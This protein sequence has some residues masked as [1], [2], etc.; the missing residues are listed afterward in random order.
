MRSILGLSFLLMS[1][2]PAVLKASAVDQSQLDTLGQSLQVKYALL[3]N[4]DDTQ[5]RT[6]IPT[7]DCFSA[8]I[9]LS[10]SSITI[11][12]STSLYFSHIAPVRGFDV[13]GDFSGQEHVSGQALAKNSDAISLEHING[14]L[15]RLTFNKDLTLKESDAGDALSVTL[16]APFWH[17]SRSDVMP[18]YYLTYAELDP[19]I[20][21]STTRVQEAGS[22]LLVN[23]HTTGWDDSSQYKR[24][25]SDN[26]PLMD[27]AYFFNNDKPFTPATDKALLRVIPQ[28]SARKDS[29]ERVVVKGITLD[30]EFDKEQ[31]ANKELALREELKK[32][33]E[34]A[35]SQ[36]THFGLQ[37]E[38]T[39][40]PVSVSLNAN[41]FT[42][43]EYVLEVT[44]EKV[45][46]KAKDVIAANYALLTLAQLFDSENN[47][48]PVTSIHDAPRFDFRGMHLDIARHFPGKATIESVIRQM[49]TYKLNKLHLHLSDDEG[50]RLQIDTLPEL[51]DIGAYRCHDL[52]ESTCLLPQLGSG[53]FK[54]ATGNGFLSK[55]D[56]IDIVK[57]AHARGI[58]V[59]PS[60]DMPGHARAA[61]V[62][63][64]ARY[65][66]LMQEG[67]PLEAQQ[68]LL[69]DKQD[70]TQYESVQFYGDNTINPCLDSTYTFI[71]TVMTSVK[72][73]HQQA[74]V[75]LRQFHVGA[76]ETAGAWIN[77]PVCHAKGV[78]VDN[79]LP[80]FVTQVQRIA[81]K[82]NLN[83]GGWSDGME[84]AAN[85]L[86][87]EHAYTNVWHLLAAGG[88][89]TVSHFAK[90]NIPVVL[91]FPDVL[92]FDFPY[93]SNPYEPGYYWGSRAT[94]TEKVFSLMPA[95]LALH[96]REWTDRMGNSYTSN[97]TV[98]A[99]SVVG[100][101][102]QLWSEVTI[103]QDAVEYMVFPRL[104]ALA[105]RAWHYADWQKDAST[106]SS[107][108]QLKAVRNNDWQ[109]FNSA[110]LSQHAPVL[111][112]QGVNVRVP[113]PAA[114]VKDGKLV[115]KPQAGLV[116]EYLSA[117]QQWIEYTQP[118]AINGVVNV[119]ARIAGTQQV[120][121]QAQL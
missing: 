28:V 105:E 64:N 21:A 72:Q 1:C 31:S 59:I 67:K 14:D 41:D 118:V 44:K 7:G 113:Q 77:S 11:P 92:Y 22:G 71:D 52:S 108:N 86:D 61:I 62:S 40:I 87:N 16:S 96:S 56:Y 20:V 115:I 101:Q 103:N 95:H 78:N 63:M 93:S 91:S 26:M 116:M 19:V 84:K 106:L 45:S 68:Y 76:D 85:T 97:D 99:S 29:N 2:S 46:I 65:Q 5:C 107:E 42:Q 117:D 109:G 38:D 94:S 57:M 17:A 48:L 3:S 35:I 13:A 10:G 27:S 100:I 49:F 60:L 104:L 82:H 50:W 111:V 83:I 43:G 53:P 90:A 79:I 80:D 58:E 112:K 110:L 120:S 81:L 102:G 24:V 39:G 12:A 55:Q 15:H 89:N 8:K 25:P 114:I 36:V 37:V 73:L 23:K 66:R 54:T 88:E 33:L 47:T 6:H 9:T 98:D 69:V 34:P 32:Q 18:N 51:T 30:F 70:T 121:R 74:G 4:L 119:R 75:P